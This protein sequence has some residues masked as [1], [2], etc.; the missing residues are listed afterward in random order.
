MAFCGVLVPHQNFWRCAND[1]KVSHVVVIHVRAGIERAQGAVERQRRFGIALFQ[2][3]PNL[4]LHEVASGNQLFGFFNGFQ[5]VR[6]GKFA[7]NR[8]IL[9][10][11]DQGC[12]HAVTQLLLQ[13]PQTL[14]RAG[15]GLALRGI[16][17]NDQIQLARQVVDHRQLF[18][19][20]QH[21]VGAAERVGR[22]AC[23]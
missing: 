2:A 17:V 7:L 3:L 11:F 1:M 4:H 16:G 12:C 20:Q 14:L 22:A 9:R 23:L 10:G 21:D 18:C 19:E 13:F 15:I 8:E 6:L 5:I